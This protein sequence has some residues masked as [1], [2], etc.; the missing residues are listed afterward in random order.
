MEENKNLTAERSLEIIRESIERSQR[1][2]TKNSSWSMMWWGMLVV[3]FS[4]LTAM[5][6]HY[7]PEDFWK[8][9]ALR[10]YVHLTDYLHCQGNAQT[11]VQELAELEHETRESFTRKFTACTGI[12]G[13]VLPGNSLPA[14]ESPRNS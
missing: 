2:I 9:L 11:S 6:D 7:E 13:R 8:P 14:R 4:L 3:V 5:M 1:T 10:H 12:T